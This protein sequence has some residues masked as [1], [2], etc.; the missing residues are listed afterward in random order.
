MGLTMARAAIITLVV[1]IA[2]LAI[3]RGGVLFLRAWLGRKIV[4]GYA[5]RLTRAQHTVFEHRLRE[6]IFKDPFRY[7]NMLCSKEAL[8]FVR[9]LWEETGDACARASSPGGSSASALERDGSPAPLPT[10]LPADGMGVD[11]F[12]MHDG[13]ILAVITLPPPRMTGEAYLIGI[14]LPPDPTLAR[15]ILRARKC[16]RYF[17]LNRW[18]GGRDTDFCE[19]KPNGKQ[20]TYNIG[21]PKHPEGFAKA[22]EARRQE[23]RQRGLRPAGAAQHVLPRR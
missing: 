14:L 6:M 23:E 16:V 10:R 17:V 15:D 2:L 20:L 7:T 11:V 5:A 12:R 3:C 13:I 19:W 1:L 21:A 9:K 4:S 22:I 18:E 8:W